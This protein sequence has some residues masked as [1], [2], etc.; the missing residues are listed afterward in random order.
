MLATFVLLSRALLAPGGAAHH[1]YQIACGLG[2]LTALHG[3]S[4]LHVLATLCV[5]YALTQRTAGTL[6]LGPICIWAVPC[7]VWLAART[8]NGLPFSLLS[9]QLAAL[10][11]A[12]GALRWYSPFNLLL[13]RMISWGCDLH[14][15]RLRR[16]GHPL[17]FGAPL[18]PAP[19]PLPGP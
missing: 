12:G 19:A 10:D 15:T 9:S 18:P 17:G 6:W 13:L 7:A 1:G 16:G 14:W 2:L 11:D 3:A 8:T 5:H 4:A